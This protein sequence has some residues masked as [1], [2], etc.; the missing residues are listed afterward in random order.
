MVMVLVMVMLMAL[1]MVDDG[2]DS[3]DGK[4]GDDHFSNDSGGDL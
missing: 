3:D 1:M 2:G 4:C